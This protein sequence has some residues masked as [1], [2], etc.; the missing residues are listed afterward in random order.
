MINKQFEAFYKKYAKAET[1]AAQYALLK[2]FT[3]NLSLEDLLA[4]NNFL[5]A[6]WQISINETLKKGLTEEDKA[7]FKQQFAKFDDL[8]AI[9]RPNIEHRRAA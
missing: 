4:W 3:L 6:K 8:E 9:I 1:E 2:D 7:W 5:D